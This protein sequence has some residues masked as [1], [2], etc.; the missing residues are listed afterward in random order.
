[1]GTNRVD[2]EEYSQ[3]H[4]AEGIDLSDK[5][6]VVFVCLGNICR[7]PAAEGAFK[8]LVNKRGLADLFEIDSAGTADYHVGEEP[9]E[10]TTQVARE[11]GIILKHHCRQFQYADFLT[12]DYIISM[13]NSNYRSLFSL[14][15][16]EIQRKK[17]LNFRK[18]D[19]TVKGEP[20]VPDPYYDGIAGFEHV[21]DI[22]ERSS[23]GFLDW[24]LENHSISKSKVTDNE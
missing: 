18:F 9:H 2:N 6:K 22:V 15:R 3:F 24:I 21:Q 12:Y 14:A 1:M 10:M 5:I 8:H 13:D 7:S 23:I 20:D 4:F 11:R 17:I 16:D 19:S